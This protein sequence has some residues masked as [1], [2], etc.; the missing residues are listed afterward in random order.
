MSVMQKI[1]GPKEFH[2][3]FEAEAPVIASYAVGFVL[4]KTVN[5]SLDGVLGGTGTL[6]TIDN[7]H[8]I[9]TAE[10]VIRKMVANKTPI[11]L[12]LPKHGNSPI[13][14]LFFTPKADAC[15]VFENQDNSDKGPDLAFVP[16]DHQTVDKITSK[17]LFYNL[18]LRRNRMLDDP[19]APDLGAW[20][21]S[22][23]ADEWT[24]DGGSH[25]AFA[26]VKEFRGM[27]GEVHLGLART[28]FGLDYRSVYVQVGGPSGW[29]LDFQG[30]SGSGI[31]QILVNEVDGAMRIT[32]RL[33]TG[34]AF[35]QSP[36]F[37]KD[38]IT[39]R[40]V[41]CHG[42]GSIYGNLVDAVRSK[43]HT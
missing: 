29:P 15:T 27:I 24:K 3:L 28:S 4:P 20:I 8:G 1:I 23:M 16:L 26:K 14:Q 39:I 38:G 43:N 25:A 35:Y 13:H 40:E 37:K 31:W 19:P 41:A 34:V 36:P 2:T 33:L 9:L 42:S 32:D 7:T 22:G 17:K 10:H 21:I 30:Y 11:G 18:T 6:V 12:I 5:A